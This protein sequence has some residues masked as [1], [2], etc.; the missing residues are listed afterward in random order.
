MHAPYVPLVQ[1]P[2][3]VLIVT[4]LPS[5]HFILVFAAKAGVVARTKSN[6]AADVN[7]NLCI[8][9]SRSPVRAYNTLEQGELPAFLPLEKP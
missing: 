4:V 6:A 2:P 8:V 5:S 1:F 3:V 9:T 7:A